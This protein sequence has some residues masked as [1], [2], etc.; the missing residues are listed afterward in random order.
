MNK[1]VLLILILIVL[2]IL[3]KC[4]L[5]PFQANN[6]STT[7]VLDRDY[8]EDKLLQ[9]LENKKYYDVDNV[10]LLKNTI[11]DDNSTQ[12]YIFFNNEEDYGYDEISDIDSIDSIHNKYKF[13]LHFYESTQTQ[14]SIYPIVNSKVYLTLWDNTMTIQPQ[15]DNNKQYQIFTDIALLN[16]ATLYP[17]TPTT[18]TMTPTT[19]TITPTTTTAAPPNCS[20][21]TRTKCNNHWDSNL[22]MKACKWT[23]DNCEIRTQ[24]KKDLIDNAMNWRDAYV[25]RESAHPTFDQSQPY[26]LNRIKYKEGAW[27]KNP[28]K[29]KKSA[30]NKW[31]G[32]LHK[33]E[34]IALDSER[35]GDDVNKNAKDVYCPDDTQWQGWINDD[36]TTQSDITR[37][38]RD[39]KRFE[40]DNKQDTWRTHL[41]DW[42]KPGPLADTNIE[43]GFRGG[44]G[45]WGSD[46]VYSNPDFTGSQDIDK[47]G[48]NLPYG[49]DAIDA[50]YVTHDKVGPGENI[51]NT[52][53]RGA[54]C[55][56]K[57]GEY[58]L[59]CLEVTDKKWKTAQ[60]PHK[61]CVRDYQ[62]ETN[63]SMMFRVKNGTADNQ[64]PP[65]RH[66]IASSTYYWKD[67]S[68]FIPNF[69][70]YKN[71]L[72]VDT[73]NKLKERTSEEADKYITKWYI[74]HYTY[75]YPPYKLDKD[76]KKTQTDGKVVGGIGS[77]E[78]PTQIKQSLLSYE[79]YINAATVAKEIIQQAKETGE[80]AYCGEGSQYPDESYFRPTTQ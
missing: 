80:D 45:G 72:V 42:Q 61:I 58:P 7:Q 3:C 54:R 33:G 5:E 51:I 68:E 53:M 49:E 69:N 11:V 50:N 41:G 60:L 55:D 12:T 74:Q 35:K 56:E 29:E 44:H 19:S 67:T 34:W 39:K 1:I 59:Q 10:F 15:T 73:G 79:D 14:F 36:N 27:C 21:E 78:L 28:R 30:A 32:M 2:S 23:N 13:K 64:E 47:N 76:G 25:L 24:D 57:K 16:T 66:N 26:K 77:R 18:S 37:V 20:H 40:S 43:T 48:F 65:F 6:S 4:L 38:N 52:M 71:R 22:H 63:P 75:F 17:L 8:Y 31:Y 46:I 9:V 70:C 62:C